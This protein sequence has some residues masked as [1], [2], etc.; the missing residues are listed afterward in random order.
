[1]S[2]QKDFVEQLTALLDSECE[3]YGIKYD[4]ELEENH[5]EVTISLNGLVARIS[6]KYVDGTLYIDRYED[7]WEKIAEYDWTV[8]YLWMIIAPA[9]WP[10]NE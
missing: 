8:K 7:A 6:F 9:L 10:T 2:G 4:Y 3:D 5:A 1:M